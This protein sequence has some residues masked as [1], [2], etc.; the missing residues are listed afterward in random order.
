MSPDSLSRESS[1]FF[2]IPEGGAEAIYI[3]EN[4]RASGVVAENSEIPLELAVKLIR[5]QS[6]D[7]FSLPAGL[8]V[9]IIPHYIHTSSVF[10]VGN[11]EEG[12][13]GIEYSEHFLDDGRGSGQIPGIII[14]R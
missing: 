1:P 11:G 10:Y 6:D 13:S 4:F 14:T 12:I 3:D 5:F 9:R 8:D 7:Y 2:L